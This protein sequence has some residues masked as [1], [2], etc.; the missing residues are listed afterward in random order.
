MM[1]SIN[2]IVDLWTQGM[3]SGI[4]AWYQEALRAAGLLEDTEVERL[5]HQLDEAIAAGDA[6]AVAEL[7]D[8]LAKAEAKEAIDKEYQRK[9]WE[10]EVKAFNAQKAMSIIGAVISAAQAI[11]QCFAQLGPIG[12]AIAALVVGALTGAQIAIIASQEPPPA[13]AFAAGGEFDVPPGYPNDSYYA[14]FQSG[15]HVSVTP[16]GQGQAGDVMIHNVMELNG[17]V[18]WEEYT[19]ASKNGQALTSKR[20]LI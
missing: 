1:S 16:A 18:L 19:R 5:R 20:S 2:S 6:A 12:G 10:A 13:P 14:R 15:E 7:E 9:K 4:D 3:M 17:R 8:E 11:I